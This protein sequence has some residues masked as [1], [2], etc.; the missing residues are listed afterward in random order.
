MISFGTLLRAHFA[1]GFPIETALAFISDGHLHP[2]RSIDH[3]SSLANLR[4]SKSELSRVLSSIPP[5]PA[6]VTRSWVIQRLEVNKR[7]VQHLIKEGYLQETTGR[8]KQKPITKQSFELFEARWIKV[9]ILARNFGTSRMLATR[10]LLSN[11]ISSIICEH[12]V[13]V[14]SFFDREAALSL[15]DP[16]KALDQAARYRG[17]KYS[18]YMAI[19]REQG[20]QMA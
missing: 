19:R 6:T 15:S 16:E 2:V 11:N 20:P 18:E 3:V 14:A 17:K 7:T 1:L 12:D 8:G 10:A 4:F 9:G 5:S 13:C